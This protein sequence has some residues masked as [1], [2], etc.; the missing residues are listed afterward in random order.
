MD[1]K[2]DFN[3]T[4]KFDFKQVGR[5]MP[6]TTPDGFFKDMEKNILEAVKDD[7]P[8]AVNI[9]PQAVTNQ[10]QAVTNQPQAVKVQ[11]KKRPVFKMIW[12]AAIAV[13]ASVAVLLVLNID[14]SAADSSL[15]SSHSSQPSQAKS[16]LEQVDQAFAQL[17]EADQAYLLDVYQEDVFLKH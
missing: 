14:F 10:P 9:Q 1:T 2:F 15:A 8:Q 6:Y 12:A 13:A 17:S 3:E 4:G 7:T 5:R 16:D 11:P